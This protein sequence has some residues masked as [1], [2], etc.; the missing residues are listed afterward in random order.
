MSHT[1]TLYMSTI[2]LIFMIKID[3][4]QYTRPYIEIGEAKIQ[5]SFVI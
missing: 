3:I 4:L 5:I 1:S 2:V